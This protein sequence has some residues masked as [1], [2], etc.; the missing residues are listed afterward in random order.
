MTSQ[1]GVHRDTRPGSA[2]SEDV[3][4]HTLIGASYSVPSDRHAATQTADPSPSPLVHATR[5]T[6]GTL[7]QCQAVLLIQRLR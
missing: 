5:I 6:T 4:E 2:T 1:P 7:T 3:Y